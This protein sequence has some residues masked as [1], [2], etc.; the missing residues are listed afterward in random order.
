MSESSQDP[1]TNEPTSS[2]SDEHDDST[3]SSLP[4]FIAVG[5]VSFVLTCILVFLFA[6]WM[7]PDVEPGFPTTRKAVPQEAGVFRVTVDAGDR[8]EWIPINLST[9]AVGG[10]EHKA[11]IL[12]QRYIIRAPN[13]GVDL[14][15]IPLADAKVDDTTEW[16]EDEIVDGQLQNPTLSHW[17]TYSYF[18]H[19][20]KSENHSYAVRLRSGDGIAFYNVVSYYCEP[21]RT[22]CV[23]IDY[24]LEYAE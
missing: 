14:G 3:I 10:N 1:G 11:D 12:V 23:T 17:Y 19:L 2:S 20:L 7:T 6:S 15:Q 18:T 16:T 8:K 5:L 4:R 13:G 9:G 21:E 22:S 24:R